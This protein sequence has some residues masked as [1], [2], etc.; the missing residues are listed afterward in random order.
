[1]TQTTQQTSYWKIE[2]TTVFDMDYIVVTLMSPDGKPIART[3]KMVG[4][5]RLEDIRAC[6]DAVVGKQNPL[7]LPIQQF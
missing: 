3:T 7:K 6:K 4:A 5:S 1:M 2:D